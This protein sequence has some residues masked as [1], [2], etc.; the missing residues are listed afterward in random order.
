M[1]LQMRLLLLVAVFWPKCYFLR[2]LR[3]FH[4]FSP[5]RIN[6]NTCSF[7]ECKS[8]LFTV[9]LEMMVNTSLQNRQGMK[10]LSPFIKTVL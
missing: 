8:T 3:R 5:Q 4:L 2:A 9:G 1:T 7:N 10:R 6:G